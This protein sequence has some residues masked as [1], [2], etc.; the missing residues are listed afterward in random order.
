ME[1]RQKALDLCRE[2]FTL[3]GKP[4]LEAEFPE[5]LPKIACG[6]IGAGSEGLGYDDAVSADHDFEPGFCIF[7]PDEELVDRRT[8]FLLERAYAKLPK[9]YK[10]LKR[11]LLAPVGGA[12]RGV[13]RLSEFLTEKTG[14]EDGRLDIS[15]WLTLPSQSLLEVV[16]GEVFFDGSGE[17]TKIREMLAFYPADIF[18][19]KLAGHLLCMAQAGQ[20]NYTR[21]LSHGENAAAQLAVF[22]FVKSAVSAIFLLNGAYEP[23]YKWS[24]RA[25]R[26]LPELSFE[27]E[28]LEYLMISD[29]EENAEEKARVIEG[30]CADVI[31]VL[32]DR[33]L[34]KM[35]CGDLEK[36]AYSVNDGIED[37]N[38]RSLHILAAV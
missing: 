32:I 22:Q 30:I 34:T 9:E 18:R 35:N 37:A 24:F 26:A 29:N 4:M 20:Y 15:R 5:L 14:T 33:N 1:E 28:L 19:K 2:Y 21:I 6:L 3:Y 12:R 25:L 7:L 16:N 13:L 17:L 10:G 27:A 23:Y 31:D 8:A 36:H 38:I 11:S